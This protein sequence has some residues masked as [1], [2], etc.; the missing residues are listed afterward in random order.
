MATLLGMVRTMGKPSALRMQ[1]VWSS[2]RLNDGFGSVVL[3]SLNR[4]ARKE[5]LTQKH[6]HIYIFDIIL[7]MM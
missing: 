5:N 2:S 4:A 3:S 1:D 6:I 7:E